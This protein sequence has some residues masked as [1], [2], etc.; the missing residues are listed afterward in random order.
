M[1]KSKP[2]FVE[3]KVLSKFPFSDSKTFRYKEI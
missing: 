1:C 3:F 2:Q